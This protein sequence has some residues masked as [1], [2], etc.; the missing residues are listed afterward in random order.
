MSVFGL[1]AGDAAAATAAAAAV[2]RGPAV[3]PGRVGGESSGGDGSGPADGEPGVPLFRAE[4]VQPLPRPPSFGASYPP[5]AVGYAHQYGQPQQHYQHGQEHHQQPPQQQL[6]LDALPAPDVSPDRSGGGSSPAHTNTATGAATVV[7]A[8]APA[9]AVSGVPSTG[10]SLQGSTAPTVR[11]LSLAVAPSPHAHSH[12]HVPAVVPHG[13][14]TGAAARG[15]PPL[16]PGA[17]VA[18]AAAAVHGHSGYFFGLSTPGPLTGAPHGAG[19]MLSPADSTG[20]AETYNGLGGAAYGDG[21]YE[22]VGTGDGAGVHSGAGTGA[23]AGAADDDARSMLSAAHFAGF[24]APLPPQP[25][26][27]VA[28]TGLPAGPYVPYSGGYA[29]AGSPHAGPASSAYGYESCQ[30]FGAAPSLV[31]AARDTYTPSGPYA[32]S[33]AL[34]AGAGDALT[35]QATALQSPAGGAVWGGHAGGHAQQFYPGGY[36]TGG[37][38]YAAAPVAAQAQGAYY[39]PLAQHQQQQQQSPMGSPAVALG[40]GGGVTSGGLWSHVHLNDRDTGYLLL[41]VCILEELVAQLPKSMREEVKVPLT[42]ALAGLKS[43]HLTVQ[44]KMMIVHHLY[45]AY[46][47]FSYK[48]QY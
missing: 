48:T 24:Y 14:H 11:S 42:R 45:R 34:G 22:R 43:H 23:G 36:Y 8:P 38:S 10:A 19:G 4:S 46:D 1:A 41:Y 12:A 20:Y 39:A 3:G 15:R 32:A 26:P 35:A 31:P 47:F 25:A 2:Q 40:G 5:I 29:A 9:T 21:G 30:V 18:A 33:A 44:Q 28:V 16:A 7:A 6:Q 27:T 17:P 13:A 37:G